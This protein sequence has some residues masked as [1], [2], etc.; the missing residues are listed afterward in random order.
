MRHTKTILQVLREA[1]RLLYRSPEDC[2]IFFEDRD[3]QRALKTQWRVVKDETLSLFELG[4]ESEHKVCVQS[5]KSSSSVSSKE[6]ENEE[7]QF[8]EEGKPGYRGLAN[9]GNTC[10]M[11]ASLQ[12]LSN[13]R[14]LREYC[15][16]ENWMYDLCNSETAHRMGMAGKIGVVF[17]RAIAKLWDE[18]SKAAY[19][20]PRTFKKYMGDF[21]DTFKGK[22]QQD[23][24][25][26]LSQLLCAFHEDTNRIHYKPGIEPTESEKRPDSVVAEEWRNDNLRRNF[27]I[28]TQLFTGQLKTCS[29]C[30]VCKSESSRFDP[31]T[32]I[33][34]PLPDPPFRYVTVLIHF[35]ENS[36][37]PLK[38]SVKVSREG[39]LDDVLRAVED[40]KIPTS[41]REEDEEKM[42]YVLA[43]DCRVANV[44]QHFIM[45][46]VNT[47][48]VLT[49]IGRGFIH[50]YH[51][52]AKNSF[53]KP[54]IV[55]HKKSLKDASEFL[56]TFIVRKTVEV[57]CPR[58]AHELGQLSVKAPDGTSHVISVPKG[59]LPGHRF[60]VTLSVVKPEKKKDEEKEKKKTKQEVEEKSTRSP[61]Q[62]LEDAYINAAA[63]FDKTDP[64]RIQDKIDVNLG[65]VRTANGAQ[66]YGDKWFRGEIVRVVGDG[67]YD[68]KV[69]NMSTVYGGAVRGENRSSLAR[70]RRHIPEPQTV[71]CVHRR[72]VFQ[73]HYFL[74]PWCL[75]TFGRPNAVR[76]N[77]E[78]VT[79]KRFYELVWNLV[80]RYVRCTK[81]RSVQT[82]KNSVSLEIPQRSRIFSNRIVNF[83]FLP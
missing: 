8:D 59:V 30:L 49:R 16:S 78:N 67:S 18:K 17:S 9:L 70:L 12:C 81:Y 64:L 33:Q 83:C 2:C 62:R 76:A 69:R 71:L 1:C 13:T 82:H 56:K 5:K 42:K 40:F 58:N 75:R 37:P 15:V 41:T 38:V 66:V 53:P 63:M 77:L 61:A 24:H 65:G 23:A 48:Q 14:L 74:N 34:V 36:R 28:I 29:T 4:I 35:D 43:K 31:F 45:T 19:L 7:V 6:D 50:V 3:Q 79:V 20:V 10:Y 68:V 44:M 39:N 80:K 27:S 51:L 57:M 32:F 54:T 26:L 22:D 60:K 25:E 73:Q 52:V 47:K 72:L 21:K 11:N 55:T 46:F